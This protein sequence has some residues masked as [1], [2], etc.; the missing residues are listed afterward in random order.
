MFSV[1]KNLSLWVW[2][3]RFCMKVIVF[4]LKRRWKPII[5][6]TLVLKITEFYE[7][8]HNQYYHCITW[9]KRRDMV[10]ANLVL[11]LMISASASSSPTSDTAKPLRRF[12]KTTMVMK[13]KRMRKVKLKKARESLL[14]MGKSENSSSPTN[15][16][17]VLKTLVHGLSKC[18]ILSSS[19][20]SESSPIML[21]RKVILI[22]LRF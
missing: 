8:M 20:S 16:V 18:S 13:T 6:E 22:L 12:I 21:C 17:K 9:V 7:R 15:M 5:R 10:G 19:S 11:M 2:D 1:L 14:S 3:L 4:A